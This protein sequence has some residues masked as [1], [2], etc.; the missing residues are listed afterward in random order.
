MKNFLKNVWAFL[1]AAFNAI[2]SFVQ[3]ILATV[4]VATTIV[5]L[6]AVIA[7]Y[8]FI[9]LYYWVLVMLIAGIVIPTIGHLIIP[10]KF[11]VGQEKSDEKHYG[12]RQV[13]TFLRHL[14]GN[15]VYGGRDTYSHRRNWKVRPTGVNWKYFVGVSFT[16]LFM[17]YIL[18]AAFP[19]FEFS[20]DTMISDLS[21]RRAW[22]YFLCIYFTLSMIPLTLGRG[23]QDEEGADG[24]GGDIQV[25]GRRVYVRM[26]ERGVVFFWGF[27][28]CEVSGSVWLFLPLG[29][30]WVKLLP[31]NLIQ[32]EITHEGLR[33]DSIRDL[34]GEPIDPDLRKEDSMSRPQT[35]DIT[36]ART[37]AI[38]R[39]YAMP[40][41]KRMHTVSEANTIMDDG[42]R[43]EIERV[44]SPLSYRE[45]SANKEAVGKLLL[46]VCQISVREPFERLFKTKK[47]AEAEAKKRGYSD[48]D[49]L[50][51]DLFYT[52]ITKVVPSAVVTTADNAEAA[53]I[54]NL[55]AGKRDATKE[56]L[57]AK[58]KTEGPIKGFTDG[59]RETM[60]LLGYINAKNQVQDG[61]EDDVKEVFK[62]IM[63]QQIA[64]SMNVTNVNIGDSAQGMLDK[65]LGQTKS[66]AA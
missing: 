24:A 57:M 65:F 12:R 52:Q 18:P 23:R 66:A 25:R 51:I 55:S 48:G 54:P 17:G 19:L 9:P 29:L 56:M 47:R 13:Y 37:W 63:N 45:L 59:M 31:K 27:A 15:G 21:V 38:P 11:L 20:I 58:A 30:S 44:S 49:T 61:H 43:K 62:L 32:R 36:V 1:R 60:L 53:S 8:I 33:L 4:G 41:L 28:I 39:G 50:G 7:S 35:C 34:K 26:N 10:Y 16:L 14:F 46:K 40:F 22:F 5:I 3:A 2:V 6:L 42:L 64:G